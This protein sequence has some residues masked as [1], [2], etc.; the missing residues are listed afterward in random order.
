M[1]SLFSVIG[2]SV[3]NAAPPATATSSSL[4]DSPPMALETPP[5]PMPIA[6]KSASRGVSETPVGE[7]A[8][9]VRARLTLRGAAFFFL[10]T[11]MR[12]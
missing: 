6:K 10:H 5:L 2:G 7:S 12:V 4:V 9:D 8:G 11:R 3:P 1:G